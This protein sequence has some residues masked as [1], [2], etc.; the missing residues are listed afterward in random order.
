MALWRDPLDEL[1][2]GFEHAV[3]PAP[4]ARMHDPSL[5][6]LGLQLAVRAVL[7]HHAGKRSDPAVEPWFE[8]V[9]DQLRR[10]TQG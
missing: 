5:P 1:V 3:P 10:S 9:I 8:A 6:R 4:S 2:D 7:E